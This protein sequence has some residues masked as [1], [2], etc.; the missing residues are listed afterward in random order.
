MPHI[1]RRTCWLV[2]VNFWPLHLWRSHLHWQFH[3][4]WNL[5]YLCRKLL[6]F[7]KARPKWDQCSIS[8]QK[9]VKNT[10][11]QLCWWEVGVSLLCSV[12]I[13]FHIILSSFLP[14]ARFKMP[15]WSHHLGKQTLQEQWHLNKHL[16]IH[17][18]APARS[19]PAKMNFNN[20]TVTFSLLPMQEILRVDL[21]GKKDSFIFCR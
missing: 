21:P 18:H 16:N 1:H 14:S 3:E 13:W 12:L 17:N 19:N 8:S 7:C 9:C 15:D 4:H 2:F 11:M 10:E 5:W 6:A 20:L